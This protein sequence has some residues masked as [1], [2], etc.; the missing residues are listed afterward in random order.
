MPRGRAYAS[1]SADP[2]TKAIACGRRRR[3][4]PPAPVGS[5]VPGGASAGGCPSVAMAGSYPTAR[6]GACITAR[7]L[8]ESSRRRSAAALDA[9]PH[10]LALVLDRWLSRPDHKPWYPLHATDGHVAAVVVGLHPGISLGGQWPRACQTEEERE[11]S[12]TGSGCATH[13]PGCSPAPRRRRSRRTPARS[14]HRQ[15]PALEVSL[16]GRLGLGAAGPKDPGD[17]NVALLVWLTGAA[18]CHRSY[19]RATPPLLDNQGSCEN[20]ERRGRARG[21][22][23]GGLVALRGRESPREYPRSATSPAPPTLGPRR[24]EPT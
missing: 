19:I 23:G 5:G 24:P 8:R 4:D 11:G 3:T 21:C 10:D 1:G 12:K 18:C 13:E 2:A 6:G 17:A 15:E 14:G 16:P 7:P 20:G 22:K 9:S